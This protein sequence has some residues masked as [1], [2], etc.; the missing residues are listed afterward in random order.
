M[1]DHHPNDCKRC[2]GGKVLTFGDERTCINCGW[3]APASQTV[4]PYSKILLRRL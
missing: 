3:V 4:S 1:E 2:F